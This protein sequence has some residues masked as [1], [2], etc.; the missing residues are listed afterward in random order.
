[1]KKSILFWIATLIL[2]T[3]F[4]QEEAK[5]L[6][7]R[8]PV[9]P[10]DLTYADYKTYSLTSNLDPGVEKSLKSNRAPFSQSTIE[11]NLFLEGLKKTDDGDFK[12][13]YNVTRFDLVNDESYAKTSF[14]RAPAYHI[15]METNL[16]IK[17]KDGKLIYK[18]YFP[19][20]V[21][22][23]VTDPDVSYERLLHSILANN[24][25]SLI[26]E[27][28]DYYLYGPQMNNLR[29]FEVEKSKKSKSDF[30]AEEFNQSVQV[31]PA[32]VDVDRANWEG[33]FSEAQKYWGTL[34][35]FTEP[36]DE[37]LQKRVRFAANYNLAATYLLLGREKEAEK[38]VQG[39]KE[40]ESSFF[41][42]RTHSPYI[43][44]AIENIGAYR[45]STD[46]VASVE[47]IAEQPEL[48]SYK[49]APTAFR[50][51]EFDGQVQDNDSKVYKG[52]IRI[53]SDSPE[54]VDFRTKSTGSS[55]GQA[56]SSIE[57]D[58]PTVLIFK[59]GEKRPEKTSLKKISHI[60]DSEG[61]IYIVAKTGRLAVLSQKENA[62]S[63][64]RYS[65]F[66]E[67]RKSSKLSLYHEFFPQ[68]DYVLKKVGQEEFYTPPAFWGRRKSLKAF[69]ADC[70]SVIEKVDKGEYDFNNKSTYLKLFEDYVNACKGGK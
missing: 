20:K 18:R 51:A 42:L 70:P 14:Q 22:L 38:Y 66:E 40:N 37:G 64:K 47:R 10:A 26:S 23:F 17:D 31:L 59:E 35:N 68:D 55:L 34:V 12:I 30:N 52:K 33:L 36:K 16:E 24:F 19:P 61:R 28:D 25:K 58:N 54:I 50:Y 67:V 2:S 44:T 6:N 69:F 9:K 11:G 57:V 3:A 8:G 43:K 29:Y 27:F 21:N 4:A 7:L 60:Q 56:L 49:S 45:N 63:T 5:K 53:L 46:K 39:I 65:L 13:I 62:S 1:M 41:G 48:P 15:G 32:L